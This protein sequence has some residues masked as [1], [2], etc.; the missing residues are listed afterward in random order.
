MN[1]NVNIHLIFLCV[2]NIIFTFSGIVLN[3]LVSQFLEIVATSKQIMSFHDHG[4]V[5][6]RFSRVHNESCRNTDLSYPLV[7]RGL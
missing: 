5:V 4:V 1:L 7:K 2:V 3:T 6:F